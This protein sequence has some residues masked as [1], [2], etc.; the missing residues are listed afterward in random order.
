MILMHFGP[1]RS[2]VSSIFIL[3]MFQ[4]IFQLLFFLGTA[5]VSIQTTTPPV[6][7]PLPSPYGIIINKEQ[8]LIFPSTTWRISLELDWSEWTTLLTTT[9]NYIKGIPAVLN[10]T[11]PVQFAADKHNDNE[12]WQIIN[13]VGLGLQQAKSEFELLRN[14]SAKIKPKPEFLGILPYQPSADTQEKALS[15]P[16][17]PALLQLSNLKFSFPNISTAILDDPSLFHD[18]FH[19][20]QVLLQQFLEFND[21]LGE[22]FQSKLHTN[23]VPFSEILTAIKAV[24]EFSG[25]TKWVTTAEED[26]LTLINH[27]IFAVDQDQ[28]QLLYF[29][30]QAEN[31]FDLVQIFS[32]PVLQTD[33]TWLEYEISQRH[34]LSNNF[35]YWTI[36]SFD[37]YDCSGKSPLPATPLCFWTETPNTPL[38]KCSL[39]IFKNETPDCP[40]ISTHSI[41]N[42][43]IR[44]DFHSWI[45]ASSKNGSLE[46]KC[47]KLT[48]MYPLGNNGMITFKSEC[49]YVMK[50]GPFSSSNPPFT[51]DYS[52]T[53][54]DLPDQ[55]PTQSPEVAVV[56]DHLENNSLTYI[57]SFLAST[58]VLGLGVM[59]YIIY[60]YSKKRNARPPAAQPVIQ[61]FIEFPSASR[62]SRGLP[63]SYYD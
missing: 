17:V 62:T 57:F 15:F 32:L 11:R 1:T 22:L 37:F 54:E 49:S 52:L 39:T 45:F 58:A 41:H 46:E 48:T 7:Q 47:S 21:G 26:V 27:P 35:T 43:A 16:I 23:L 31:I 59:F 13:S 55:F 36:D 10:T 42:T 3:R 28:I 9:V 34:F 60:R 40:K 14:N 25:I 5:S 2:D 38:D 30:I 63:I 20:S 8:Q 6:V 12:M 56:Y 19:F 61:Q 33:Q 18:L 44:K 51:P 24:R 29:I 4:T 50:N 53:I